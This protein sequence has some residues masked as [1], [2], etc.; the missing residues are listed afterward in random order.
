MEFDIG[1]ALLCLRPG[2]EWVLRGLNYEN[3]EWLSET[4]P[5][6]EEEVLAELD[7]L[8]KDWKDKEYQRLRAQEYPDF[9]EYL[10]GI[11]KGDKNQIN[12]YIAACKAVKEKYPKP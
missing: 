5:P 2:E 3:L 7:R 6:T 10:D 11:V 12:A 1:H 9:K 8:K 4:E